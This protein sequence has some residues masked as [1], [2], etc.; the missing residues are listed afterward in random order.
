MTTQPTEVNAK[1]DQPCGGATEVEEWR[2][3]AGYEGHY[4]VS[5]LGRVRG[6]DRV[7]P[8]KNGTERFIAGRF[9]D[10]FANHH[11]YLVVTL[12]KVGSKIN[13]VKIHRLVADTFL[14]APDGEIASRNGCYT[15]C[16]INRNRKDNRVSNLCFRLF[17]E[18]NQDRQHVPVK[19][20]LKEEEVLQIRERY[21]AGGIT[22]RKLAKE[23]G[24]GENQ[25][26][27]I[28]TRKCWANI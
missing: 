17:E 10:G 11:G 27:K 28:I 25:I 16:H 2:D 15:V 19:E 24:I 12:N 3:V 6:L 23:Y 8:G 14:E 9:Y 13:P 5:S 18:N 7:V 22:Q 20:K 4:Q 1:L 26:Q 21:A